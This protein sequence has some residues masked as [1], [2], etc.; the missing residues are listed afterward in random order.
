[1]RL[2]TLLMLASLLCLTGLSMTAEALPPGDF[3]LPGYYSPDGLTPCTP[4]EVGRYQ[5]QEGATQCLPCAQGTFADVEASAQC[6]ECPVGTY[7]NLVES[8]ACS[9]CPDGFIAPTTGSAEC[10]PCD[11]G[12]TSN[13]AHSECVPISTPTEP[14]TW[15][16][17]KSRYGAPK[18]AA[19]VDMKALAS[20]VLSF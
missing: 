13:A 10:T 5:D 17:L 15:G 16:T 6:Q 3:C 20:A 7:T 1:M 12:F 2:A 18:S 19:T 4:C 9:V 8:A 14:S 11:E